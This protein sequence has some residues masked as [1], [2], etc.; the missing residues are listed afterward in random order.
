M[1]YQNHINYIAAK[2]SNILKSN[3]FFPI[4]FDLFPTIVFAIVML[5][6]VYFYN[7]VSEGDGELHYEWY[8]I[9]DSDLNA[10]LLNSIET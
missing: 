4:L 10:F 5:Q 9:I 6:F 7:F 8:I 3:L 1:K 2:Q